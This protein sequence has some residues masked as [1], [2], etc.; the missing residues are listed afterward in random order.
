MYGVAETMAL[1]VYVAQ[2]GELLEVWKSVGNHGDRWILGE[3]TVHS[4]GNLQL[5]LEGEWGE[6]FRSDVALDDLSIEQGYCPG[7]VTPTPRP[8][9]TT[10]GTGTSTPTP[11]PGSG[12]STPKPGTPSP[13][14]TTPPP[15]PTTTTPS[16]GPSTPKPGT[17]SPDITTPPPHP[18]TT[19]P[20]SG[21]V[22]TCARSV[23]FLTYVLQ[24]SFRVDGYGMVRL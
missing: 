17:P 16:S 22:M 10:P 24:I 2:D 5:V 6:D 12:P 19:T 15:H 1:R 14:I 7:D 23:L 18:T 4:T 9:T 3:V 21:I 8:G 13:D 20:S 11:Q